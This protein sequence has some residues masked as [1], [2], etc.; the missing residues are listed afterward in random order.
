MLINK[1]DPTSLSDLFLLQIAKIK[2]NIINKIPNIKAVDQRQHGMCAA[3]SIVRK[4]CKNET[5]LYLLNSLIFLHIPLIFH[6]FYQSMNY[7]IFYLKYSKY[8]QALKNISKGKIGK[9]CC[10]EEYANKILKEG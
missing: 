4:K 8:L 7:L 3:I 5:Y 10:A 6:M 9:C 1:K 2:P